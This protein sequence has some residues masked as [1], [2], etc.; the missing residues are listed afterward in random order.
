MH[1]GRARRRF[2]ISE[3]GLNAAQIDFAANDD[4]V[5]AAS[6]LREESFR[7]FNQTALSFYFAR[8]SHRT[9]VALAD[10]ANLRQSPLTDPTTTPNDR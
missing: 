5:D 6:E 8:E 7:K 1:R 10:H 4:E 9:R 2:Q 3:F